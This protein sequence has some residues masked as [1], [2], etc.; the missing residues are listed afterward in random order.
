MFEK[1]KAKVL[2][3]NDVRSLRR[4]NWLVANEPGFELRFNPGSENCGADL[5]SRPPR[6][7]MEYGDVI[8][9]RD[10]LLK[11]EREKKDFFDV[12]PSV[13]MR[14]GDIEG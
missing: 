7:K 13:G 2:V 12:S 8:V 11:V 10:G 5:L 4:W 9:T 3:D 1:Y 14:R 6:K